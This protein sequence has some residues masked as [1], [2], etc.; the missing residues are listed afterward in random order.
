VVARLLRRF[1]RLL[2][3]VTTVGAAFMAIAADRFLPDGVPMACCA[4]CAAAD[5]H[6]GAG[7]ARRDLARY[8]KRGPDP[9]TRY[10]LDAIRA[11]NLRGATLL[12]IG[13]GV[14]VIVH[15]LL[16]G[17]VA[18]ATHVEAAAAYR[19]A[20]REEALRRDHA[21]RV[22]FVGGDFVAVGRE[23]DEA[24]VVTLDRVICCYPD[25]AALIMRST[26]KA[27][28]YYAVSYP[29]D[30]W[31]VRVVMAL[32]NLI[33]RLT[34]NDFR[35]FV[36]PNRAIESVLTGAGVTRVARRDTFVWRCELYA[37]SE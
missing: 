36:H 25:Y 17:G 12:D 32:G 20:A 2:G 9:T 10:L 33:R 1:D 21:D 37:R 22:R 29:R 34:R 3:G 8:R 18:R 13:A 30:R 5:D 16:G 26:A 31:P 11:T 35:T 4:H 7:T 27:R 24:D 23:L 19:A 6:F 14:G 28:R 15:E